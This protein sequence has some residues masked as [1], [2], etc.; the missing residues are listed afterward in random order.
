MALL[1]NPNGTAERAGILTLPYEHWLAAD[2]RVST[3]CLV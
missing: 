2:P 3:V 1:Q